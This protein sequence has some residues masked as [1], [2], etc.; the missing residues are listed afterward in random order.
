MAAPAGAGSTHALAQVAEDLAQ[1]VGSTDLRAGLFRLARALHGILGDET[2][3]YSDAV[4]AF[5]AIYF[6]GATYD[7]EDVLT[8]FENAYLRV[9]CP[10]AETP[11]TIAFAEAKRSPMTLLGP[12]AG[13][14]EKFVRIVSTFYWL[15]RGEGEQDV[16]APVET[17]A[18]LLDADGF[19]CRS[20][21]TIS[22]VT[23]VAEVRGLMVRQFTSAG[24]AARS[25]G[26]ST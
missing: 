14:G 26:G 6:Q 10:G 15:Q 24:R 19:P 4:L 12:L 8:A 16:F 7:R 3:R 9:R 20:H 22:D 17:L 18:A 11:L 21:T 1:E 25:R 23:G 5:A 13:K 2:E